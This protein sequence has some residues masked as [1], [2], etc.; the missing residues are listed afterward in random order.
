MFTCTWDSHSCEV[1]FLNYQ[2]KACMNFGC[3]V[4]CLRLGG[5]VLWRGQPFLLSYPEN[6]VIISASFWSL[7]IHPPHRKLPLPIMQFSATIRHSLTAQWRRTY[8][9]AWSPRPPVPGKNLAWFGLNYPITAC[10][11]SVLTSN[12]HQTST[13]KGDH[14]NSCAIS[15]CPEDKQRKS[16]FGFHIWVLISGFPKGTKK[17]NSAKILSV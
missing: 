7:R 14:T 16:I 12:L 1:W 8:W 17:G 15:W 10:D 4:G 9:L 5:G 2:R 6:T 3:R 13:P 11:Q